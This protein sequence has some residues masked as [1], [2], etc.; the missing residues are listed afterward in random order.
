MLTAADFFVSAQHAVPLGS[1]DLQ[2]VTHGDAGLGES[3]LRFAGGHVPCH[4]D[5]A[6]TPGKLEQ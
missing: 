4:V 2:V 6:H 3:Q 5:T 1:P